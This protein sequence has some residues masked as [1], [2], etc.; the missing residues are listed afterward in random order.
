MRRRALLVLCALLG[1]LLMPVCRARADDGRETRR[2]AHGEGILRLGIVPFNSVSALLRI[3]RPLRDYLA[4]V[5]ERDVRI[6]SSR[7]HEQFLNNAL[8]GY[9]DVLITTAHFLP[10]LVDD[11]FVALVRYRN[12][13]EVMLVTRKDSRIEKAEDL[14]GQRVALPDRLSLYHIVGMQWLDGLHLR[15]GTDYFPKEYPSHAAALLAVKAGRADIAVTANTVWAQ[16]GDDV[17]GHLRPL[18]ANHSVLPAMMTLARG[19]LGETGIARIRAALD[20]FPGSPEGKR[21]FAATGYGGYVAATAGDV[22]AGRLYEPLVRRWWR[23]APGGDAGG[24]A[25]PDAARPPRADE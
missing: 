16:M 8:D 6:Y 3:H 1:G 20:A 15:A 23:H 7:D 12:P 17:H 11:G 19:D 10:M 9:F 24:R 13:L 18:D 14:R 5:L 21:F 4:R 2:A 25:N 22:A